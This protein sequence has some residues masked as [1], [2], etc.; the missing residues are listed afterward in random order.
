MH[1]A[2]NGIDTCVMGVCLFP[3][4]LNQLPS[5]RLFDLNNVSYAFLV[6]APSKRLRRL[7][8][9]GTPEDWEDDL[10][11]FEALARMLELAGA[12]KFDTSRHRIETI[13]SQIT[14]WLSHLP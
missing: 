3:W 6:C 13:A 1:N 8:E 7:V 10:P 4:Q 14:E 2:V 5:A 12:K 11:K 9:R